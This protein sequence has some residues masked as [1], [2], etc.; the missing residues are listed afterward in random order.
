MYNWLLLPENKNG[1]C[2]LYSTCSFLI[3]ARRPHES[4]NYR[5]LQLWRI[6]SLN[7]STAEICVCFYQEHFYSVILEMLS[8]LHNI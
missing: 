1:W 3:G 4:K 5:M 6:L 7:E 2:L 8:A